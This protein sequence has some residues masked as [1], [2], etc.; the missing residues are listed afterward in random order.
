MKSLITKL[1]DRSNLIVCT[2]VYLLTK[3]N[4]QLIYHS[5]QIVRAIVEF[6][7]RQQILLRTASTLINVRDQNPKHAREVNKKCCG[8]SALIS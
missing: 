1:K 3:I 2:V 5:D 6:Q 4:S 7:L 8:L